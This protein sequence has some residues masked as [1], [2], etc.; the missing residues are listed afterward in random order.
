[1]AEPPDPPAH[2]AARRR[3]ALL[4][5]IPQG[6][7]PDGDALRRRQRDV[8]LLPGH[9][10]PARSRAGRAHHHP[11]DG[12]AADDRRVLVQDV[13]RPAVPLPRQLARSH[14]ELH[15]HDVRGADRAVRGQP[16]GRTRAQAAAHPPRRPRAELL[17]VDGAPRRLVGREPLRLDR[18][19]HQRTL[20]PAARRR[21]PGRDRDAGS[22]PRLGRRH[23]ALRGA[24][25]EPRR[26]L[27]PL[28]LRSPR[29]QELRPARPH[30]Q[31]DGRARA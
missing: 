8:D 31:S 10:R 13:D 17:D 21:E 11:P 14:R 18:G 24:R 1:M 6:C 22:D 19:G 30:P 9:R 5:R 20:G 2:D 15:A 16:D 3:Q 4:R 25:E 29:V 7:A 27:P 12:Q 26:R 23:P 28:R